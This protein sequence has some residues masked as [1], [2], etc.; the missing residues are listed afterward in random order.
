MIKVTRF[1]TDDN[2]LYVI[3][4][5]TKESSIDILNYFYEMA[6]VVA[7]DA[8]TS[9]KA[10]RLFKTI[11]MP[12]KDT[13]IPFKLCIWGMEPLK[14]MLRSGAYNVCVDVKFKSKWGR[15]SIDNFSDT[16]MERGLE[17]CKDDLPPFDVPKLRTPRCLKK[18]KT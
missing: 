8:A 7:D 14:E 13:V 18:R 2:L 3:Q 16:L 12:Y 9:S 10:Y 17:L 11:Q 5:L 15:R 1:T 6:I 4:Q